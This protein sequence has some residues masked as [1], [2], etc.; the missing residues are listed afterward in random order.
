M[1]VIADNKPIDWCYRNL[2]STYFQTLLKMKIQRE[3]S[4]LTFKGDNLINVPVKC[5][6]SKLLFIKSTLHTMS[7]IVPASVAITTASRI[8]STMT[9]S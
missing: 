6:Y 7:I 2:F 9:A 5:N 1:I 8:I 4:T 3:K